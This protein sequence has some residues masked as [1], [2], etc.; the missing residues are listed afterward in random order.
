M[1]A[2]PPGGRSARGAGRYDWALE[3]LLLAS[4]PHRARR[5]ASRERW[6]EGVAAA[7]FL[8]VAGS[9]ALLVPSEREFS[10]PDA[11]ALV[12]L[13][14]VAS[15]VRLYVGAG[16]AMP[17]QLVL[18]PM[19]YWLPVPLVPLLV[20]CAL[21]GTALAEALGRGHP[22]A[23]LSGVAS[24]WYTLGA[25]AVF[26]LAGEPADRGVA[27]GVLALALVAQCAVD[28]VTSG[29]R[30]C[31]GRGIPPALQLRVIAA[32]YLVDACLTPVAVLA[33][34]QGVLHSSAIVAIL[35]M[36]ALLAAFAT[37]RRAR[38][39]ELTAKLEE[40]ED[41]RRRHDTAIRRVGEAYGSGLDRPALVELLLRTA[42]DALRSQRGHAT[43]GGASAEAGEDL[44]RGDALEAA[45]TEAEDAAWRTGR[46]AAAERAA[47]F[48]LAQPLADGDMQPAGAIAIGRRD[49]PFDEDDRALLGYLANQMAAALENVALHERVAREA[50]MDEL[51][52]L[53]NHRHFQ[54][55]LA[56]ELERLRRFRRSLALIMIDIDAF[57]AVNDTYGH[58]Q[59]DE[60]LRGVA[61]VLR[62]GSRATDIPARYGGEELAL[63]MPETDLDGAFAA[64]EGLR[65][66]VESLSFPLE[67]GRS[68]GVTISLGV[69]ATGAEPVGAA[70]LIAAAD[71]AL[72][73]AKRGGRNRTMRA[74]APAAGPQQRFT[75][76]PGG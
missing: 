49:T 51:T 37:D 22:E 32:V 28:L 53:P 63:V 13:Y 46:A 48:A 25:A 6:V 39:E 34:T 5:L 10:T 20:A 36:L 54:E 76:R 62:E 65:R 16:Y 64:A 29:A 33:A 71:D 12:V 23:A 38:I 59:G 31:L 2:D 40:L 52:G 42:V 69:A 44:A 19:L 1:R 21:A 18:V 8:V 45:I 61:A 3:R 75:R 27:W 67:D 35:L 43:V 15:R 26:L 72:Y 9:L 74:E 60:V 50:R 11:V 55:S 73:A 30:E 17:T 7:L 70:D 4:Q 24:S 14:G 57:K 68:L 41:E 66:D 47:A 56:G 58:Q